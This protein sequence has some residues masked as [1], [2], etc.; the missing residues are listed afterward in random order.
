MFCGAVCV[1]T[2]TTTAAMPS[3]HDEHTTKP[4]EEEKQ[5]NFGGKRETTVE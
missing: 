5:R 1:L 3:Y 4:A 2:V